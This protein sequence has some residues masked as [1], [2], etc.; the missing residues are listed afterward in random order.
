MLFLF[1]S[2]GRS[3]QNPGV[4]LETWNSPLHLSL[5]FGTTSGAS[6][7]GSAFL[8]CSLEPTLKSEVSQPSVRS[9]DW[10]N[11]MQSPNTTKKLICWILNQLQVQ[12]WL[13]IHGRL[14]GVATIMVW[15]IYFIVCDYRANY[16]DNAGEIKLFSNTF[17][18][19]WLQLV[20]LKISLRGSLLWCPWQQ[21]WVWY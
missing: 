11:V 5:S 20:K 18:T 8:L 6:S 12:E 17:Y 4:M 19:I 15:I 21:R 13:F 9:R 10:G 16:E 3:F 14:G 1:I 7:H 2:P